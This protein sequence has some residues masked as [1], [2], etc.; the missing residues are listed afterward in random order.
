MSKAAPKESEKAKLTVTLDAKIKRQFAQLCEDVGLPMGTVV[1]AL[2][3]QAVRKQE[4]RI[5]SLDINGFTPREAK[6]LLR[7]WEEMKAMHDRQRAAE[8]G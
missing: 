7:R 8:L 4:L 2:M 1:S 5:S 3:S 6:E